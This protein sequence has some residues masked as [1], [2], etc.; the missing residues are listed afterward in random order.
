MVNPIVRQVGRLT[1]RLP[2]E[3]VDAVKASA[4]RLA[5]VRSPKEAL[6]ALPAE[7]EHLVAS[8]VPVLAEHPLPVRSAGQARLWASA[9]AGAAALLEQAGELTFLESFGLGG[10]AVAPTV[11]AGTLLS[12]V[13]ELWLAVTVR[14]R[15][16]ESDGRSVDHGVLAADMVAAV[17]GGQPGQGRGGRRTTRAVGRRVA[18]RVGRR[19]A[20]GLVP[21]LGIFYD[22]WDAQRTI[23]RVLELPTQTHPPARRW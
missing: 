15:Q 22:G 9:S 20:Y 1:D 14:V 4:G 3:V 21:V 2:S 12:W 19:W 7:L 6:E 18:S 17:L 11:V 23:D 8:T 16:L 5:R 10:V 13:G